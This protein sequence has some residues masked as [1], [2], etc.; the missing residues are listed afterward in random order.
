MK[1]IN[2]G[3]WKKKINISYMLRALHIYYQQC[4]QLEAISLIQIT[5]LLLLFLQI[6]IFALLN[7]ILNKAN[8]IVSKS[9]VNQAIWINKIA[10][11]ETLMTTQGIRM[12]ITLIQS[13]F[14]YSSSF[15]FSRQFIFIYLFSL[16]NYKCI[17]MQ[18]Q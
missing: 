7:D 17:L 16:K 9:A 13:I 4:G 1:V 18:H 5:W 10:K 11:L 6:V 3:Y 2:L 8:I 14:F 15:N 12:L